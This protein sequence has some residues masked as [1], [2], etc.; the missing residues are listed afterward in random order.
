MSS[1]RLWGWG[2]IGLGGAAVVLACA[3]GAAPSNRNMAPN[4]SGLSGASGTG[5]LAG[6]GTGGTGAVVVTPCLNTM[7]DPAHCGSCSNACAQG[8]VCDQGVCKAPVASCT[9]P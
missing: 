4:N 8:Q 9:A 5:N 7:T 3:D 1:L 6:A 2:L